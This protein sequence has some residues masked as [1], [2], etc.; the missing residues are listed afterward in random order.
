MSLFQSNLRKQIRN[1]PKILNFVKKIH[2]YSELFT[3][4]LSRA[5]PQRT[6]RRTP[7]AAAP[8]ASRATSGLRKKNCVKEIQGIRKSK[9]KRMYYLDQT[10]LNGPSN[11]WV[12]GSVLGRT[13]AGFAGS[14]WDTEGKIKSL[15]GRKIEKIKS[16]S[17]SAVSKL[18]FANTSK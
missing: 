17:F 5:R 9:C 10:Y 4:L 15:G 12:G 3:S 14:G 2:Y 1:L 13:A 16:G 8:P 7:R 6:T 11:L 18:N